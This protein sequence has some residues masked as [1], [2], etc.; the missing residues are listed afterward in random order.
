VRSS[1]ALV[2]VSL[3]RLNDQQVNDGKENILKHISLNSQPEISEEI[4]HHV[5]ASEAHVRGTR[6]RVALEVSTI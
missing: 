4:R 5:S 6:I 1:Q 2:H 3:E